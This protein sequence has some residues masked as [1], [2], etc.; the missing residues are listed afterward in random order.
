MKKIRLLA[1]VAALGFL[2]ASCATGQGR[3]VLSQDDIVYQAPH[4]GT[5]EEAFQRA[6][7][8]A[9]ENLQMERRLLG[10]PADSVR[11]ADSDSGV[12]VCR[13]TLVNRP[14]FWE[15]DGI[16]FTITMDTKSDAL[17]FSNFTGDNGRFLSAKALDKARAS[18]DEI[19]RDYIAALS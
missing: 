5:H 15:V 6:Q 14:L 7:V 4:T 17:I 1:A 11:Y 8:W 3:N 2:L 13:Y 10:S 16:T 19:A 12:L 18:L 9:A